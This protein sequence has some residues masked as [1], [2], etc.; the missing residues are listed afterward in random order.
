M[1]N[2]ILSHFVC[3]LAVRDKCLDGEWH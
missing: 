3:S 2:H 1:S